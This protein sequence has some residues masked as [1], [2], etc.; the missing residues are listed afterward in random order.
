MKTVESKYNTMIDTQEQNTE[1]L[2]D[3]N[4]ISIKNDSK[5]S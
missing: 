4:V 2:K 1:L 3:E 5:R